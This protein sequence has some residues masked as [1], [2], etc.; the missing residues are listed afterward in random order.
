MQAPFY[1]E[2]TLLNAGTTCIFMSSGQLME[3]LVMELFCDGNTWM[4]SV[5]NV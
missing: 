4:V 3:G 1:G 2:D 5:M